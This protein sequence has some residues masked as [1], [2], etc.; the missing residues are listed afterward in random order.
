[1][2]IRTDVPK[3]DWTQ[4]FTADTK[5]AV[6]NCKEKAKHLSDPLPLEE[7]CYK[8]LPNPNST[9]QLTEHLS[10]RGESKL[11]AFH[12]RFAHFAN[13]GMRNSLADN[14]NLAGTARYNLSIRHKRG[15]VATENPNENPMSSLEYRKKI[16]A[17][18]D[19]AV[20][21]FNHSELWHIN[22]LAAAVNCSYP[23]PN[24]EILPPDNG[25]R[26][27]SE[28]L[29]DTIPTLKNYRHGEMDEC[30]CHGCTTTTTEK[31]VASV[32]DDGQTTAQEETVPTTP[33]AT[34]TSPTATRLTGPRRSACSAAATRT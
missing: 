34:A 2:T 15:L 22:M 9:H 3:A 13:C 29:T 6:L 16:P 8:M 28:Y 26:F 25:E 33:F 12:D 24:A 30:L 23:F 14:L 18:W 31:S 20:P 10:K 1:M 17:G 4:L 32:N 19:K 5:T 21:Y 7:M 27:F 11:E